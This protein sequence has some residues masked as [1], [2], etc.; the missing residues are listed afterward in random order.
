MNRPATSLALM[1]GACL[2]FTSTSF[3]QIQSTIPCP[4]GHSYWDTLSI[5]V[6]G[7]GLAT[8]HHWRALIRLPAIQAPMCSPSGGR[9]ITE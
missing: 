2:A 8:N 5:L 4:T 1:L 9:V 7:P 3:A 6:M